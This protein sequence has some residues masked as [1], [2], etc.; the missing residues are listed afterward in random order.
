MTSGSAVTLS[1][2]INEAYVQKGSLRTVHIC[3]NQQCFVT[4]VFFSAESDE[5]RRHKCFHILRTY[6]DLHTQKT[7]GHSGD[8]MVDV[9]HANSAA[10]RMK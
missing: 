8:V 1:W 3:A 10:V 2:E 6:M 7:R 9:L 4:T 5:I